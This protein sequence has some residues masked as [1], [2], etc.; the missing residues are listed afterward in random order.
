VLAEHT[1]TMR[2]RQLESIVAELRGA[3]APS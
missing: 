2:A 3:Q 1:G